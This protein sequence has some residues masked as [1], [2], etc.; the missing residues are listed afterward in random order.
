MEKVTLQQIFEKLEAI[1]K[2]L[3]EKSE[4]SFGLQTTEIRE[5]RSI[6]ELQGQPPSNSDGVLSS[7]DPVNPQTDI[8]RIHI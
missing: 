8:I 2:L 4:N 3:K 7:I 6:I 5:Q 1:E